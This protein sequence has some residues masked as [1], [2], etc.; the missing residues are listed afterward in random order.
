ML[1]F[2]FEGFVEYKRR[3]F[4]NDVKC[5]VQL[6]LNKQVEGSEEYERV[7]RTC[8]LGCLF[9]TYQFHHWLIDKGYLIV[10]PVGK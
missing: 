6:E 2:M 3:E 9:S 1:M 7:R 5:S 4:C 10:R 8:V